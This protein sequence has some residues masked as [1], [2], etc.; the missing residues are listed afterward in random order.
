MVVSQ[1]HG[2][3]REDQKIRILRLAGQ[4]RV[5]PREGIFGSPRREIDLDETCHGERLRDGGYTHAV[6]VAG[7][8]HAHFRSLAAAQKYVKKLI[9]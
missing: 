8:A 7:H 4:A 3:R 9:R 6:D 5:N 1:T 2:A